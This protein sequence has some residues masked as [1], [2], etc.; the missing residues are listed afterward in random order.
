MFILAFL[1]MLTFAAVDNCALRFNDGVSFDMSK[2]EGAADKM[3]KKKWYDGSPYSC[4]K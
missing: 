3:E 2:M 1:G 4:S